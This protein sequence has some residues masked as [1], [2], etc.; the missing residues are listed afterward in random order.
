MYMN[1]MIYHIICIYKHS[2]QFGYAE[3]FIIILK[4]LWLCS[5]HFGYAPTQD[6]W[7]GYF[8]YST[9]RTKPKNPA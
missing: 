5:R 1:I 6:A 9:S 7:A 2:S 8:S 3:T 4:P